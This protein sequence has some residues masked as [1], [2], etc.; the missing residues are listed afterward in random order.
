MVGERLKSLRESEG[1]TQQELAD[2]LQITRSALSLYETNK[3]E[4][5]NETIR[6]FADFFEVTTDYL[7]GRVDEP[8]RTRNLPPTIS[9][10]T[11]EGYDTLP[12]EAKKEVEEYIQYLIHKHSKKGG[13]H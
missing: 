10:L 9:S 2:R 6:K 8:C 11:V 3:R 4:P 5:D 1:L 12:P 13:N 7:L